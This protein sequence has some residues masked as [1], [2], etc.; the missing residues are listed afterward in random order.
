MLF[1]SEELGHHGY[2]VSPGTLYPILHKL[3]KEKL[4]KSYPEVVEGKIRKYYKTTPGG[5]KAMDQVREKIIELINEVGLN[6]N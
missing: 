2:E 3:E 4:L 6:A 1:R 5:V